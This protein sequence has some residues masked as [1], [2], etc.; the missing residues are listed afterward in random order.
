MSNNYL[1]IPVDGY[2]KRMKQ[3]EAL[4]YLLSNKIDKK[5]NDFIE[6]FSIID[7]KTIIRTLYVINEKI[8][9]LIKNDNGIDVTDFYVNS[10]RP[11]SSDL[12]LIKQKDYEQLLRLYKCAKEQT[13]DFVNDVEVFDEL[14]SKLETGEYKIIKVKE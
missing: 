8:D 6:N 10:L 4:K 2:I 13:K 7:I 11:C 9:S 12:N 3:D 5:T 1:N 14:V